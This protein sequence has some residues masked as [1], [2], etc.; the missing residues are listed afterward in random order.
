MTDNAYGIS[1]GG[2]ENVLKLIRVI[3]THI[4]ECIGTK[5]R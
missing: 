1:F 3:A 2:N 5:K 4:C